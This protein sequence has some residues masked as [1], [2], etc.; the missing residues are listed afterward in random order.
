MR[1]ERNNKKQLL[2]KVLKMLVVKR[3]KRLQSKNFQDI[4]KCGNDYS[5]FLEITSKIFAITRSEDGYFEEIFKI[6]TQL[7]NSITN[8]S[9]HMLIQVSHTFLL[10]K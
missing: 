6:E 1:F 4:L 8:S 3:Y 9:N 2:R 10:M 7:E 5:E